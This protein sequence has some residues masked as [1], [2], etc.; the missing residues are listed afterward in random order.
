MVA[1]VQMFSAWQSRQACQL[2][3]Q[4][5]LEVIDLQ[6]LLAPIQ[7]P[8]DYVVVVVSQVRTD[9]SSND[10]PPEQLETRRHSLLER[11][12]VNSEKI[13]DSEKH[14]LLTTLQADILDSQLDTQFFLVSDNR[15][16][17]QISFSEN[18]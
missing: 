11:T 16:R 1:H 7:L 6:L 14:H 3:L 9:S 12:I 4:L 5:V 13:S 18:G 2:S 8:I 17:K 10:N 15:K